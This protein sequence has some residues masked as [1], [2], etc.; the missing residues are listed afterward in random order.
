MHWNRIEVPSYKD[1]PSPPI[2]KDIQISVC[3]TN[4]GR[5][6]EFIETCVEEWFKQDFPKESFEVIIVDD[7]SA[8]TLPQFPNGLE[9]I[10][11]ASTHIIENYPDWNYRAYLLDHTRTCDDTHTFNVAFKRALGWILILNQVDVIPIGEVLEATWRHHNARDRLWIHPKNYGEL[12]IGSRMEG[13]VAWGDQYFP[14]DYAAS[15]RKKYIYEVEGRD[16]KIRPPNHS[17]WL[18]RSTLDK[19]G[20]SFAEDPSVQ[21]LHRRATIPG[22]AV[23]SHYLKRYEKLKDSIPGYTGGW[24]DLTP[25]EEKSVLMTP[26]M[27]KRLGSP[28]PQ[29]EGPTV[30]QEVA[31]EVSQEIPVD[32]P[33]VLN[34][35]FMEGMKRRTETYYNRKIKFELIFMNPLTYLRM[36]GW[37]PE[38]HGGTPYQVGSWYPSEKNRDNIIE[39]LKKGIPLPP[40]I[41]YIGEYV[42][43]GMHGDGKNR[44]YWSWK[45]GIKEIPVMITEEAAEAVTKYLASGIRGS[46]KSMRI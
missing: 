27:K 35:E 36:I 32:P 21:S 4:Y 10:K 44:A 2:P 28:P 24:G 30:A 5:P 29:I 3:I 9:S 39:A 6:K 22:L 16:E 25:D 46:I 11:N 13:S 17:D 45:L 33:F 8:D 34:K 19:A 26:A 41:F 37:P 7:A 12:K 15:I 43:G 1:L 23:S 18:L 40:V 38:E 31:Q 20:I 14:H 42:K